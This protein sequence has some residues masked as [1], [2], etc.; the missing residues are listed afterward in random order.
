LLNNVFDFLNFVLFSWYCCSEAELALVTNS[1]VRYVRLDI[2]VKTIKRGTSR[3][4]DASMSVLAKHILTEM[5]GNANFPDPTPKLVDVDASAQAYALSLAAAKNRDRDLVLI[6]NQRKAELKGLLDQLFDYV[7]LTGK[8]NIEILTSSG[9][10][11]AHERTPV[12]DMPK[13]E[14]IKVGLGNGTG[15][16]NVS[17]K[18]IHGADMYIYQYTLSPNPEVDNWVT[19]ND[20][21]SKL[22]IEGLEAGAQYKFRVAAVGSKGKGPWSDSITRYVA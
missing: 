17:I 12:G 21:R 22:K 2:M 16:V 20:S 4:R 7:N 14:N 10:P 19:I 6:K 1:G 5:A 15:K 18:S 8:D 3:L 9:F 11:L 13:P